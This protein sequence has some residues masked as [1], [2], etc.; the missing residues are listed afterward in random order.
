M[1]LDAI[2]VGRIA[3]LAGET[4]FG[5][6]EALGI[7]GG[8]I[9]A[10]GSRATVEAAAGPGTRRL[11]L[12]PGEV[13]LPGFHD[14][15]VHL[16]D[17]AIARD[18]IDLFAA[19]TFDAALELVRA[20]AARHPAPA[21]ILGSGWDQRR[22]GRWP[23]AADLNA[24]VPGRHVALRS[25]DLHALWASSLALAAAGIGA[26][27]PD[28]PGGLIQRDADGAPTGIFFEKASEVVL[29]KAPP[30]TPDRLRR[31]IRGIGREYLELGVVG[32]HELGTLFPDAANASLDVY[33]AMAEAG[34][35]GVRLVAGVRAD[36][37]DDAIDRG[38]RS[39]G[40]IGGAPTD[41][42]A[43]GWLKQFADGTLGSRTAKTLAPREGTD[44]T[45]IFATEPQVLAERAARAAAA[46]ISTTIHAIGDGGVRAALDALEPTSAGSAYMPRIEHVQ[47][48]DPDDRARFGRAGIAAS[49]QPIH[50]REDAD[51]ARRD[52]GE[53]AESAGYAWRSLL[54]AG[55][56]VAL[57]TDIPLVD[58]DLWAGIAMAVVRR[59]PS[60]P[61]AAP[62]FGPHQALTLDEALRASTVGVA[63]TVRNADAARLVPGSPADLAILP[64][65][66]T[67]EHLRAAA[68][69]ELRP[70]LVLLGGEVAFE[71]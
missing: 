40:P 9:V 27:T 61:A 38:L 62:D 54:D 46:G 39:G 47:L 18:A 48:C 11:D 24:A 14:A 66:P 32:V 42:L 15:H 49:V 57:G 33:A 13:A 17:A 20:A 25:F 26:G 67:V 63:M 22:W 71:R 64:T 56:T 16:V 6:V 31:A 60:W 1:T 65:E 58:L 28:P 3:T 19:P 50:L 68:F 45:G 43:F 8:R 2:V 21:W 35:L 53:R 23:T 36:G 7:R 4:G 55:A 12:E 37:L 44:E 59:D 41:R 34:Q 5:W 29:A 10:A 51:G 70:R 30:P 69:D 52:W